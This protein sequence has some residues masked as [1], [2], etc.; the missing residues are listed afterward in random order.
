MSQGVPDPPTRAELSGFD[1]DLFKIPPWT[2][3]PCALF[4]A[5][6]RA[7]APEGRALGFFLWGMWSA[8]CLVDPH[9]GRLNG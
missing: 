2:A 9:Q 7:H 6:S 3:L 8:Q 5:S 4:S 1:R